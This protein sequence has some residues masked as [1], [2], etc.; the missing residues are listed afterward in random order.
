MQLA[1]MHV[2]KRLADMNFDTSYEYVFPG[3]TAPLANN[4]KT[5]SSLIN[6]ALRYKP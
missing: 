1:R 3:Q 5:G 2:V 6:P 4:L